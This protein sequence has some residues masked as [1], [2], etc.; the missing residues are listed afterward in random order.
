MRLTEL[1][2]KLDVVSALVVKEGRIGNETGH[3]GDACDSEDGR[4]AGHF[5]GRSWRSATANFGHASYPSAH[6]H[7]HA[8]VPFPRCCESQFSAY[9]ITTRP[10]QPAPPCI[11]STLPKALEDAFVKVSFDDEKG[12]SG[13]DDKLYNAWIENGVVHLALTQMYAI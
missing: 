2:P 10:P 12:D 7:C 9:T 11:M 1:S 8:A 3:N 5:G 13:V 4:R 6:V